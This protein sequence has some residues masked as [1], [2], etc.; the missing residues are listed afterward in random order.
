MNKRALK[1]G[2][3]SQNEKKDNLLKTEHFEQIKRSSTFF[4]IFCTLNHHWMGRTQIM[5]TSTL[6]TETE[7]QK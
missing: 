1:K 7:Y 6:Y 5:H 3:H 2:K 4:F